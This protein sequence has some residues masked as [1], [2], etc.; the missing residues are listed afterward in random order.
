MRSTLTV[1]FTARCAPDPATACASDADCAPP[2]RCLRTAQLTIE[3]AGLLTLDASAKIIARGLAAAGDTIGPDGGTITL[4]AHDVNLAG[5]IR[6]PAEAQG[7]L[8]VPAGHAGRIAIDADGTVMLAPTAF[9]DASTSSGGCG[10]TIGI[11]NG[12]KTPATLSAAGL[13][14]VDGATF[15]GTIHLVARDRLA[16]TGTLQAS[17]T[18][19]ALSSRPPCTDDP[20]GPP[21]CGGALEARGGT[22]ELEAARVL[23]QGL[24]RARGRE[25]E[26]GIV[27]LEGGREVTLDSSAPSPAIIVT[28][29]Q[30]D[31]FCSGGVVSLSASAG[32]VAVLRGAIEADGLSTGLGSDAGAFSITATGATRCLADAAPCTSTADCAPGD[33]CVETGGQVSV[34]APLSAAGGAGLGSGCCLDPRCGRGCEV[35]GSGAVA[36]SAAINVGGGKQR[37]GSG[38]K[39]SLSGGGDLSVG[40]GPITAEA[41]NGGTIILT[42]GSRIGSAGNV[43]GALTVVNGTQVRADALRDDGVGGDVQLE[44]CEVTLE[45]TV[46][47]R[48]DG[49]SHAGPVSVI[50]HERLAIESLVQVSALPDGPITLASRTDASVAPDATF[51]P[52]STPTTD[53]TLLAC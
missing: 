8:G 34:Q 52:P 45:P 36:V 46:A 4:S 16:L 10:G 47:L 25:A 29:G 38:G 31:R 51:Q 6:V 41:A 2:A 28:G 22:I 20:G 27:R 11:G 49:G 7:T 12:A 17:N 3:V 48:A 24:A 40:P 44:G 1:G 18:D 53:P 32:D 19:G 14:V 23:F 26:G 30:T 50:A 5:S 13:L 42:G 21:P 43:S 15:G 33:V 37:G 39:V 9:L 35:R